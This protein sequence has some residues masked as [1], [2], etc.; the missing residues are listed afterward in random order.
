MIK[1]QTQQFPPP[2]SSPNIYQNINSP[3]P[4]HNPST[5]NHTN[6]HLPLQ[7]TIIAQY[8]NLFSSLP[9]T[10]STFTKEQPFLNLK[11]FS[12]PSKFKNL[13][14]FSNNHQLQQAKKQP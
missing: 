10:P 2:F 13:T 9:S 3:F 8:L 12:T 11:L 4:P 5:I 7:P 14:L 1:Y 6:P